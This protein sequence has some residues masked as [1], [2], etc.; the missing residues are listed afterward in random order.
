MFSQESKSNVSYIHTN[1]ELSG[2][3]EYKYKSTLRLINASYSDT[4]YYNCQ[5]DA[6]NENLIDEAVS[7]NIYLYVA[8]KLKN[9]CV[10]K[11]NLQFIYLDDNHLSARTDDLETV[12]AVQYLEA[13]IPCRPTSPDVDVELSGFSDEMVS[14]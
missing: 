6:P 5:E 7:S 8:G 4:G 1:E 14:S 12:I 10:W 9:C 2:K 11:E 3:P 13:I